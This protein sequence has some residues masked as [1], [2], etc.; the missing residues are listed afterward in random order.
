MRQNNT[1]MLGD[2]RAKCSN[3][4]S[5][6]DGHPDGDSP[7]IAHAATASRV[8]RDDRSRHMQP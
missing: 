2:M 1:R 3:R 6:K 5:V 8:A 7:H 4:E